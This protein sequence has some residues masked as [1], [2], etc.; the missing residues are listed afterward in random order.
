[1]LRSRH[2]VVAVAFAALTACSGGDEARDGGARPTILAASSLK[3]VFEALATAAPPPRPALSFAGSGRLAVQVREGVGADVIATADEP[4]LAA[5]DEAGLLDG[6]P[7]VFATNTLAIAVAT[8]NPKKVRTLADLGRRDL[9]VVLASP[10][11]PAGRYASEVLAQAGVE[12]SP[13]SLEDSVGAVA[14]RVAAGEADAGIVYVTD[15]DGRPGLS[16]VAIPAA[17]NV[18][19]RYPIAVLAG[20]PRPQAARRFVAFVLSAAGRRLLVAAGFGPP[21]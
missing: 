3:G 20:G 18:V 16:G 12:A 15:V 4:T 8:G 14:A 9:T 5:L 17:A 13:A 1:M 19:A 11:V 6:S 10:A 2:V 21:P 7:T